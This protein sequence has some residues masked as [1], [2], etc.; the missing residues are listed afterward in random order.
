M[1]ATG[2]F[3]AIGAAPTEEKPKMPPDDFGLHSRYLDLGSACVSTSQAERFFVQIEVQ[4][5][6]F[7][8]HGV[9][10]QA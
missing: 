4:P 1:V 10:L 6:R 2:C 8:N 7:S 9:S 3:G 5:A